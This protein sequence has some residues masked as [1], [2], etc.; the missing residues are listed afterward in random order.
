MTFL[1]NFFA[2]KLAFSA[3][4]KPLD[5]YIIDLEQFIKIPHSKFI[6]ILETEIR[7]PP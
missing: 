1:L 3:K 5:E 2:S 4:S 7:S 6:A